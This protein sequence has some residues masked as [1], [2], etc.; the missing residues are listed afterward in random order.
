MKKSIALVLFLAFCATCFSQES[1]N[2]RG[3]FSGI[4]E[5][6]IMLRYRS[7]TQLVSDSALLK[8]GSFDI[9]GKANTP[10]KVTIMLRPMN[11]PADQRP[12]FA[13]QQ[14]FYLEKG[15]VKINGNNN[16][17]EAEITGGRVQA[18]YMVL[19]KQLKP[20]QDKMK[21]LSQKMQQYFAEKNEAGRNELFPQLRAIRMDMGKVED[22]FIHQHP[23]SYVSFDLVNN[24]AVVIDPASFE[25]FYNALS[26]RLRNTEEGK[27]LAKKLAVAKRVDIGQP[28]INFTQNNV[29]GLPVTLSAYRGKYILL[30]FWASWCGPCRA[31]NPNVLKAYNKFKDRNFDVL[32]VSLDEKK[33]AWVKAI[34]DDGMPWIHVSDLQG[35]KNA[36]A[37]EYG[38]SAIPQNFLIDPSGKIIAK[39]LRGEDLDKK[40]EA[41][42]K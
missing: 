38:I 28:A 6:Q 39:N 37:Q 18:D 34:K 41:F 24:K 17:R 5:G 7:G 26:E 10:Q 11:G 1:F 16:V 4:R 22:A 42:I 35:F 33:E 31:E 13:D 27:V 29:E 12:G 32:A 14:D 21:P 2:I 9:K 36:P 3:K 30:D 15:T 8:N 25:P 23:D 40:L 19:Q 20:L